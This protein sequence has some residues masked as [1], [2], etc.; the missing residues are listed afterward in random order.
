MGFACEAGNAAVARC[1]RDKNL[2]KRAAAVRK[3]YIFFRG[4]A[5]PPNGPYRFSEVVH[6]MG[7]GPS[8]AARATVGEQ[9]RWRKRFCYFQSGHRT[10]LTFLSDK[11]SLLR[12]FDGDR[13]QS[14]SHAY[15]DAGIACLALYDLQPVT[16]HTKS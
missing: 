14:H 4:S 8:P 6:R 7:R 5:C 16:D 15:S 10:N 11:T 9:L 3:L 1:S 2:L 12:L 13:T